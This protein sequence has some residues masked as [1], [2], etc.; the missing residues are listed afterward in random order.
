[1]LEDCVMSIA[2]SEIGSIDNSTGTKK[3]R[4]FKSVIQKKR[5]DAEAAINRTMGTE[6]ITID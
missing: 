3:A 5:K 4:K 6:R 1:M 2:E